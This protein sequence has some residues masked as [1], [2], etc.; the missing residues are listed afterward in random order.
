MLKPGSLDA[1]NKKHSVSPDQPIIESID[2]LPPHVPV[3]ST[4]LPSVDLALGKGIPLGRIIEIFGPASSGKT[5]LA[6]QFCRAIQASGEDLVYIDAEHAINPGYLDLDPSKAFIVQPLYGE[7]AVDIAIEA[8][9]NGVGLVVI[10]SVPH[11]TPKAEYE[12]SMEEQQR[13]ALARM[14]GKAIRK[15]APLVAN[16]E[17]CLVV[18]NQTRSNMSPYGNPEVTPGGSALGYAASIRI[19]TK[20]EEDIKQGNEII[21]IRSRLR[22]LKNK[23]APPFREATFDIL[24]ASGMD[25][26]GSLLDA[27]ELLGVTV[28]KG[29]WIAFGSQQ[30]QGREKA[31]VAITEDP[32]LHVAIREAVR[33]K[34]EE[35]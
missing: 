30:W 33:L 19:R 27:A 3:I 11:L 4:G 9:T 32:V 18:I 2:A 35:A 5:S 21:G 23:V 31:K 12:G 28:K 8:V 15:L 14:L 20:K 17:S 1:I 26:L 7:Q 22:V 10:D 6:L 29:A 13:G 24:W 16:S 25:S 34:M